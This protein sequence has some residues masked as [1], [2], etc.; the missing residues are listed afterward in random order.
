MGAEAIARLVFGGECEGERSPMGYPPGKNAELHRMKI[1]APK[2]GLASSAVTSI[3]AV[4]V[5]VVC[6]VVLE[7]WIAG[8]QYFWELLSGSVLHITGISAVAGVVRLPF[9]RGG[10]KLSVICGVSV[11]VVGFL[12]VLM[13]AMSNI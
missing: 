2:A 10:L 13:L 1:D 3:A 8:L 11:A 12:I 9:R 7:L 6:L 5:S 4:L